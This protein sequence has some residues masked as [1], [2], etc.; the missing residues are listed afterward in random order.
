MVRFLHTA[1][2]QIGMRA[3]H[4]E[5]AAQRVREERLRAA[6][7][8]VE[9]ARQHSVDFLVV[10][11]DLFEDNAVERILVQRIADILGRFHGPVLLISGNHD[12]FVPGSVWHHPAWSLH[13]NIRLLT[14]PEPY[15]MGN[16]VI[17]PCPLTEKHSTTDPTRWIDHTG[18]PQIGI[19]VAHGTVEGAPAEEPFFPI[20]RD[21][22]DRRG[23]DF[24]ALGHWH[25][26]ASFPSADG[27][28]RMAYSGTHET[29]KFGERD[30]GNVLLVEIPFRAAPPQ[31]TPIR[32][33]G[34]VWQERNEEIRSAEDA[35]RV[36]HDLQAHPNPESTLLSLR[37]RGVLE[38]S[39]QEE[40]NRMDELLQARFLYARVDHSALVPSPE[41]DRWVEELPA[42]VLRQVAVRLRQ[43]ANPVAADRPAEIR[44]QVAARA[45][46]E[47]YRI[48]TNIAR[49]QG[50]S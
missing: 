35:R 6:E 40:L 42:G 17:Y 22:A 29:T 18:S 50:L 11:G 25:S 13:K 27:A 26:T 10:A 9:V 34:L 20:P 30:S 41:D 7:R 15:S 46:V 37:L 4:V 2:W 33:G 12:P 14:K 44:S 49:T 24:V 39:A 32:T 1:D 5:R 43:W 28:I 31:V 19:A 23:L 45:L 47:L 8:V 48:C 36:C 21:A 16:V 3:A 38:P